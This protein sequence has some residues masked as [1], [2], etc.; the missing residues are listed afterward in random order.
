M[1]AKLAAYQNI[2]QIE[3][4]VSD[5]TTA[6]IFRHLQPLSAEDHAQLCAFGEAE[7]FHIYLQPGG[8]N[9]VHKIWPTDSQPLLSYR[10]P[11]QQLELLFHPSDFTQVNTDINRKMIN[12]ALELLKPQPHERVLDLFCGLGNFTLPLARY[13]KEIVGVEGESG[14][15]QR[16]TDNAQHNKLTNV[17]FYCADLT[18]DFSQAAWAN[19]Y[20]DKILLDPPRTGALEMVKTIAKFK[21]KT[22]LYV[23]CNPATLVRDTKELIAHGYKL[24]HTGVMDMFPHTSHVESI[25]LFELDKK[26]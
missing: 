6:L 20:F 17:Q 5:D 26:P 15:V 22:I 2:A 14:L 9:T 3:V 4:A 10:L 21:A 11:D 8:I 16:A 24:T 13:C 1:I 7:N 18:K 23:S 19:A 25:A 12:R